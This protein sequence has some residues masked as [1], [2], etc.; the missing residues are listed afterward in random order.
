MKVVDNEMV[1]KWYKYMTTVNILNCHDTLCMAENGMDT[2]GDCLITTN[3]EILLNNAKE[4]PAIMCI[5]RKATKKMIT[6]EEL[7]AV[8]RAGTYAPTGMGAQSPIIVVVQDK[9]TIA[10]LSKLNAAVMLL[11]QPQIRLQLC[12]MYRLYFLHILRS[13]KN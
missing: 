10:Y 13:I 6:E 4:L 11:V 1:R 5:Q 7:Q 8:L 12:L 2:D 9:E 3:N